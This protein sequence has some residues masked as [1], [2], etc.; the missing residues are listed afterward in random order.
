MA[1]FSLSRWLDLKSFSRLELQSFARLLAC[2]V[3]HNEVL[4]VG[5]DTIL[6]G[7]MIPSRSVIIIIHC[8][9]L[10]MKHYI[11]LTYTSQQGW[12]SKGV[13]CVRV[14]SAHHGDSG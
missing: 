8:G 1:L 2:I 7:Y 10:E 5:Y 14:M 6:N 13:E 9:T 4:E 12:S 11:L 3:D